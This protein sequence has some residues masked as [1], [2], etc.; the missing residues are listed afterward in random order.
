M[1]GLIA[2]TTM[3]FLCSCSFFLHLLP[4]SSLRQINIP[5]PQLHRGATPAGYMRQEKL[6]ERFLI[7]QRQLP[8]CISNEQGSVPRNGNNTTR[9]RLLST[10]RNR[11]T[12][13]M[14][15]SRIG[16][17]SGRTLRL[18]LSLLRRGMSPREGLRGSEPDIRRVMVGLVGANGDLGAEGD[19]G[20]GG[21]SVGGP[22]GAR[23]IMA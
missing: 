17:R 10:Q 16:S 23:S 7:L 6:L 12:P 15:A 19:V 2:N 5:S 21:K 11:L 8:L 20:V 14:V 22:V 4:R 9:Q 13:R 3:H 1:V 18:E